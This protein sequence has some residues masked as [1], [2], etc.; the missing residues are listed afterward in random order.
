MPSLLGGGGLWDILN[1][2]KRAAAG[3]TTLY[4]QGHLL[5]HD[6][7]GSGLAHNFVPLTNAENSPF[8]NNA[9]LAHRQAF[10]GIVLGT[11]QDMIAHPNEIS[12]VNYQVIADYNRNAR[13]TTAVLP[14]INAG[15]QNVI[16]ALTPIMPAAPTH[17]QVMEASIIGPPAAGPIPAALG[18]PWPAPAN[19]AGYAAPNY[20]F[21]PGVPGGL[22]AGYA[23]LHPGVANDGVVVRAKSPGGPSQL[24]VD[25]A[26][27]AI[28]GAGVALTDAATV[29][30]SMQSN[31]Q[32]WQ[33]EDTW[34]PW[35]I[36]TYMKRLEGGVYS[37]P[38]TT[39]IHNIIED[40]ADQPYQ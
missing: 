20:I 1:H 33:Y 12:E 30:A 19:F 32:L 29:L 9:N 40:R 31:A 2:R 15:Y 14:D 37:N 35:G 16:A 13:T 18:V 24:N 3:G 4:A 5:H 38:T 26:V 25:R 27:R 23:F 34:V 17:A 21:H 39:F 22:P 8:G 11:Y 6:L 36:R 28:V 7:G 10:E